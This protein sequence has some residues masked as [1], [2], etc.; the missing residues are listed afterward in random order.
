MAKRSEPLK[1]VIQGAS[2]LDDVPGIAAVAERYRFACAPDNASLGAELP[3]AEVLLGW[4]FRGRE[5]S[6]NW[7]RATDL[8]WIHWGGA[9]VDAALFPEL[10]DSD[11]V[12]TNS[13]GLFDR[14]MAEY[15]LG[16][17]LSEIK[18]LPETLHLQHEKRW[19]HRYSAK[20]AGQ[21]AVIYGV[22]SIGREIARLLRA[23]GVEVRGV[24]RR[25]RSGDPDFGTVYGPDD[26]LNALA[27]ADWAIGILPGTPTTVDYFDAA[28]FAA[29][30]PQARFINLGRGTAVIE[31]DLVA[32]LEASAI[33][34]ALLDV[35]RDEPLPS[36]SPLWSVRNLTVS[37]H[38]SGDYAGYPADIAQLFFDNLERYAAGRPLLNV[39]DKQLGFVA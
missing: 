35:F 26:K 11:V 20:L 19:Q 15:T 32:A 2:S 30:P 7:T 14:P 22:G 17:M 13:R 23:V 21:S 39:V 9:G 3:E 10:I 4:N 31:D 37:P 33:A 1:I 5:L 28:F 12:L 29:M 6:D 24:G 18:L 38:L 25:A 27:G 8:K 34:G 16:Y 36:E